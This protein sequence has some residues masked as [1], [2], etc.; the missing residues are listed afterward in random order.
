MGQNVMTW[1]I[2]NQ[3]QSNIQLPVTNLST[4]AYIVKVTTDKGEVTKKIL[5]K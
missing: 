1:K 5:I 2:E 4:G 3:D